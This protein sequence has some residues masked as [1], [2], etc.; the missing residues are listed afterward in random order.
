MKNFYLE[1]KVKELNI[2]FFYCNMVGAQDELIFDG[3]SIGVSDNNCLIA[4]GE[5]FREKIVIADINADNSIDI[6]HVLSENQRV[7]L[8]QQALEKGDL[9]LIGDV[10]NI[11]QVMNIMQ[12]GLL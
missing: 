8:M 11:E 9:S 12:N 6:S 1:Y 7:Q 5:S 10:L 2:P 4:Y 3:Q